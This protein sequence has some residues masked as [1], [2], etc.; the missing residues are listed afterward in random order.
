MS[1]PPSFDVRQLV[2]IFVAESNERLDVMDE[3][4]LALEEHPGADAPLR[5]LFRAVHTFK[6]DAGSV[7]LEDVQAVAHR[8]EGLLDRALAER[9][10]MA[11]AAIQALFAVTDHFRRRLIE[12]EVADLEVKSEAVPPALVA[13]LERA[14][15]GDK[16]AQIAAPDDQQTREIRSGNASVR[17]S[18]SRLDRLFDMAGE[19]LIARGRLFEELSRLPAG[20]A[21][22]AVGE[23]ESTLALERE[24]QEM[25][26][27][28]RLVPLGPILRG[29]QRLVRD[30]AAATGKRARL[31][32]DDSGV[33]LDAHVAEVLRGPLAHLVRNAVDHGIET[34]EHRQAI[35]KPPVG[36]L[37]IA[38]RH[39]GGTIQL[40]VED[41]G[42]GLNLGR[43]RARA[44]ADGRI[45][46]EAS[47]DDATLS[48]LV[49]AQ[50]FSTAAEVTEIS[51]RGVGLDVV[52]EC[53]RLLGGKLELENRPGRGLGIAL[54]FPLTVALV[55][56]FGVE[57]GGTALFVPE[58]AVV[59]CREAAAPEIGRGR[60]TYLD[61]HEGE[62]LPVVDLG[63]L[64]GL[65]G[66]A[67]VRTALLIVSWQGRHYGL[68][69]D[70]LDGLSPR[71]VKPLTSSLAGGFGY[72]GATV[73]GD[74][75]VGLI[76]D[77]RAVL[78]PREPGEGW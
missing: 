16:A 64:L 39:R 68:A 35:G 12:V 14:G 30:T 11:P 37:R 31:E 62:P 72:V 76:L 19:L 20:V 66:D 28:A 8:A 61:E 7:G 46:P 58:G 41:D 60:A 63:A 57:V 73:L 50:G 32:I 10:A 78:G 3:A 45:D 47:I 75:R 21:D 38:A 22:R 18:I 5:E 71:V 49:T 56:A 44:I 42:A 6:G 40:V 29:L 65:G 24:L 54:E 26:L 77:L 59:A 36:L 70:R 33:E 55:E 51:G 25:L 2:A 48:A 1:Q 15:S 13:I 9:R 17:V 43:I 23:L 52:S 69:V 67:A 4:L 34:P 74:G 53:A 27:T